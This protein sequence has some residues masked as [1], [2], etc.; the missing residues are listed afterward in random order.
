MSK[1]EKQFFLKKVT[2]SQY[3][4]HTHDDDPEEGGTYLNLSLEPL[5]ISDPKI[6]AA[7]KE[8]IREQ[9]ELVVRAMLPENLAGPL[10]EKED[11]LKEMLFRLGLS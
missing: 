10:V 6:K 3:R 2:Q 9:S 1:D 11:Y 7:L 5:K 8:K 4:R